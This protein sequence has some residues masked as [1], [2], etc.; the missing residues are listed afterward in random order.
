MPDWVGWKQTVQCC[1]SRFVGAQSTR[2]DGQSAVRV[3]LSR[4]YKARA[5]GVMA[6]GIGSASSRK[7]SKEISG[8]MTERPLQPVIAYGEPFF[9]S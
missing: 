3:V 7:A 5:D 1:C 6:V 4:R 2:G 8:L 9:D